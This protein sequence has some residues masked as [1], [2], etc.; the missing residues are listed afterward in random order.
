MKKHLF[1]STATALLITAMAATPALARHG[2]GGGQ[3]QGGN[4][5]GG[6]G[7]H[8]TAQ[9]MGPMMRAELVDVV[10]KELG[11]SKAKAD[12]IKNKIYDANKKSIQLRAALEAENLELRRMLEADK[13]SES[14]V[15]SQIDKVVTAEG[16]L[17][18]NRIGLLLAVKKELTPAQQEQMQQMIMNRRQ[19]RGGPGMGQG[20]GGPGVG[21]AVGPVQGQG[22]GG[23]GNRRGR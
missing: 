15:M 23:K 7:M 22:R 21:P 3:G 13:V 5:M 11:L 14:K 17:R 9:G 4:R 18:K 12:K 2:R 6:A 16:K 10:A 20:A 1:F 19:G 8:G